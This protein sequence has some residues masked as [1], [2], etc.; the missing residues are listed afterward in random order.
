MRSNR[1]RSVLP[2]PEDLHPSVLAATA[3]GKLL[4]HQGDERSPIRVV[5]DGDVDESQN[6]KTDNLKK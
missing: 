4:T 5:L 1:R 6:K 3:P 2:L